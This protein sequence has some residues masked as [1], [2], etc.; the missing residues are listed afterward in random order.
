MKYK[1]NS[2]NKVENNKEQN[3]ELKSKWRKEYERKIVS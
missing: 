3:S 1:E 2:Y